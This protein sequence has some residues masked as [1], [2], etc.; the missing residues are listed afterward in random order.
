MTNRGAEQIPEGP[1]PHL[2]LILIGVSFGFLSKIEIKILFERS[3]L[4]RKKQLISV[5]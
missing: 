4:P 3:E 5:K 2:I 1:V